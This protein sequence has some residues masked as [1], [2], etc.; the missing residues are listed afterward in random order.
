MQVLEEMDVSEEEAART[1]GANEWEVW[2]ILSSALHVFAPLEV[3]LFCTM[4][5]I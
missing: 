4:I 2:Q 1:M 5:V 3:T